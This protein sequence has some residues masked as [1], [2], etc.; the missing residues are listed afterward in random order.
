MR[1][2]SSWAVCAALSSPNSNFSKA[3]GRLEISNCVITRI[4]ITDVSLLIDTMHQQE[5]NNTSSIVELLNSTLYKYFSQTSSKK[6]ISEML[7]FRF[8][9]TAMRIAFLQFIYS[10]KTCFLR[11]M[12]GIHGILES[13]ATQV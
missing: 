9:H 11:G 2:W 3:K 4:E 12:V 7:E 1:R 5:N 6:A 8:F 10:K 13:L